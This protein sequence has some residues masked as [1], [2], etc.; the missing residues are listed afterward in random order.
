M[1]SALIYHDI[2]T[3]AERDQVGFPGPL[4]ARYKLDPASFGA[5]M[6][7]L[8]Q[9]GARVGLLGAGLPQPDVTLTFD[10]GGASALEAAEAVE[11]RG[12]RAHFFVTTGRLGTP[13][14]IGPEAVL[15]LRDRGHL[16]GSHSHT[17]PTYMGKLERAEIDREW[18][19][20]RSVLGDLLGAE[21]PSSASVPGGYLSSAVV[22]SAASAGYR[23]LMTSEPIRRRRTH[24]SLE[25]MGRYTIWATTPPAQAAAYARGDRAARARLWLEWRAKRGAKAVSP[26]IYQSMR[27]LRARRR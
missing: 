4:A 16:V 11:A 13:G 23:L 18:Q 15:E 14:F 20:S 21:L 7:A 26:R 22:E 17:H 2:A 8:A 12:W 10:D 1:T 25:V 9:T 5:H 19:R 6:D 24:G 3:E 27:L